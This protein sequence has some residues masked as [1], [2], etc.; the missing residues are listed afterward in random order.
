MNAAFLAA[1]GEHPIGMQHLLSAARREYTKIDKLVLE[2]EF[3]RYFAA[4]QR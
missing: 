3:G 2:S 4:V 1:V